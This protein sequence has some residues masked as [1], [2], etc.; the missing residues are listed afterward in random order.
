M[1]KYKF[2]KIANI[3]IWGSCFIIAMIMVFIAYKHRP[4]IRLFRRNI[5]SATS[6]LIM[7]IIKFNKEYTERYVELNDTFVRLNSYRIPRNGV[8]SFN[9][10]YDSIRKME[11]VSFPVLGIYKVVISADN[12]PWNIPVTWCMA[13]RNEMFAEMYSIVL[14]NHPEVYVNNSYI[15][16]IE[17]YYK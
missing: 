15:K 13:K 4:D 5:V 3:M 1:K 12:I 9:I 14:K 6:L 16:F 10:P 7:M 2:S 11:A 17:R 8:K